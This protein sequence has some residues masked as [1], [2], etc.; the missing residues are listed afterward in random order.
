MAGSHYLE[1]VDDVVAVVLRDL[2]RDGDDQTLVAVVH[3]PK[4]LVDAAAAAAGHHEARQHRRQPDPRPRGAQGPPWAS[5]LAVAGHRK[6]SEGPVPVPVARTMKG[7]VSRLPANLRHMLL[8]ARRPTLT[9]PKRVLT[10]IVKEP[11]F[12]FLSLYLP[13]SLPLSISISPY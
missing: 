6:E 1:S 7:T 10:Q 8:I 5:C 4:V 11:V 2:V 13:E 12:F 3:Q 9:E